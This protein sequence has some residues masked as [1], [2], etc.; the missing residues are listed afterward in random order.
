LGIIH[1][2]EVS[3][4]QSLFTV[5]SAHLFCARVYAFKRHRPLSLY[6]TIRLPNEAD[7]TDEPSNLPGFILLIQLYK[8]FDDTFFRVWNR[9][10]EGASPAWIS[11]LQRKLS[12]TLPEYLN[13]PEVQSVDLKVSQLWLKVMVWQLALDHGLVSPMAM[14]SVQQNDFLLE[15]CQELVNRCSTFSHQSMEAHGLILVSCSSAIQ[16]IYSF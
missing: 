2:G 16:L 12:E 13:Y 10:G 3:F 14:D 9:A 15:T 1:Y 5:K 6:D 8:I 4:R 11:Q 7:D